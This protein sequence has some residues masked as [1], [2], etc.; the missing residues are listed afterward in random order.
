M[1]VIGV[2]GGGTKTKAVLVDQHGK[3]IDEFN[4]GATNPHA[5]S[6]SVVKQTLYKILDYF[7]SRFPQD[8]IKAICLGV[9][10]VHL[11]SE[12]Q[13]ITDLIVAYAT[14]HT[15]SLQVHVQSDAE[16]ALAAGHDQ[17][18]GTIVIA[19][20]GSIV[21]GVTP[22]GNILRAGGWG[23]ILGDTGSGYEIGLHALQAVMRSRDGIIGSTLLTKEI[24]S[25]YNISRIENLRN[26]V[27]KDGFG[28]KEIASLA[29]TCIATAEQGDLIATQILKRGAAGLADLTDALFR[30]DSSLQELPVFM[31]GSMFIHAVIFR[32]H[33]EKLLQTKGRTN[34]QLLTKPPAYGAAKIA[35]SLLT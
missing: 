2:D 32:T 8:S 19:G 11:P 30:K 16:I 27:Y 24:M 13:A 9:A 33:F 23:A 25:V 17:I 18:A 12:R 10:G 29:K 7:V 14:A 35:L 15:L 34:L 28:K 20:T 6:F 21:Y 4:G 22:Q 26:I 1:Y 31:T 5:V 3:V